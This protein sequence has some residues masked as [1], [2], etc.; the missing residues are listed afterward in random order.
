MA[1]VGSANAAPHG[2]LKNAIVD[3]WGSVDKMRAQFNEVAAA[4]FGSGWAWLGVKSDGSL[5]IT[6]TANQ[7]N[8]NS[9]IIIHLHL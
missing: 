7:G 6:S 4:R 9:V 2:P 5:G 1:P 3:V 8:H